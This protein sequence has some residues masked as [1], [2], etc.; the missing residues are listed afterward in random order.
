MGVGRFIVIGVLIVGVVMS[1]R[2]CGKICCARE[3]GI[4]AGVSGD[5]S[6]IYVI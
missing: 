3:E 4:G 6:R 2:G 1:H 5:S